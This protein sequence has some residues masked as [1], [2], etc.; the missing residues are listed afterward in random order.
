MLRH[1]K[2]HHYPHQRSLPI[3]ELVSSNTPYIDVPCDIVCDCRDYFYE[4]VAFEE[5]FKN[6]R[7][8]RNKKPKTLQRQH[9]KQVEDQRKKDEQRR[10]AI[11]NNLP[12]KATT[13][14]A[15]SAMSGPSSCVPTATAP[16]TY[17]A[18]PDSVQA[19]TPAGLVLPCQCS[20][21]SSINAAQSMPPMQN[22]VYPGPSMDSSYPG[23]CGPQ[24]Q[25]PLTVLNQQY[26]SFPNLDIIS[27]PSEVMATEV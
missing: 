13:K 14:I 16:V 17:P 4:I 25:E 26:F 1:Y 3:I 5:H 15:V 9:S 19:P 6:C 2:I 22:A 24:I 27:A 11:K 10:E 7:I 21:C 8:T 18:A 12:H 20:E 23:L